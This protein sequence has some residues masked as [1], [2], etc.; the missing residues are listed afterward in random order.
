M[1]IDVS[2]TCST[3]ADAAGPQSFFVAM[4]LV[5]GLYLAL[6]TAIAMLTIASKLNAHKKMPDSR[7][8]NAIVKVSV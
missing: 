3:V 1:A 6:D 2:S 5:F 8:P 4:T 7:V